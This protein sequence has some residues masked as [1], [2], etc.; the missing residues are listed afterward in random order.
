MEVNTYLCCPLTYLNKIAENHDL[1][2]TKWSTVLLFP[3][4]K[5]GPSELL[6][7]PFIGY[8]VVSWQQA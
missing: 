7:S 6:A 3:C 1:E 8:N 2:P 5:G 4:T